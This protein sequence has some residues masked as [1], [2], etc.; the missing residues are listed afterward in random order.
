MKLFLYVYILCALP[1]FLLSQTNKAEIDTIHSTVII[2]QYRWLED[3]NAAETKSWIKDQKKA[4]QKALFKIR[5]KEKAFS[6]INKYSY[7]EVDLPIKEGKHFYKL[8]YY[9]L[10]TPPGLFIQ[11]SI[12]DEPFRIFSPDQISIK[13]EIIISDYEESNDGKYLALSYGRN[14]S[15]WK[16]IKVKKI[17]GGYLKDH[18]I[19]V[20]FS[21]IEWKDDGFFYLKYPHNEKF[22]KDLNPELLYHKLHTE[23]EEDQVIFRRKAKQTLEIGFDLTPSQDYLFIKEHNDLTGTRNIFIKDLSEFEN[24][25]RPLLM[26]F[27]ND[28]KILANRGDT[29]IAQTNHI[30]KNQSIVYF[31]IQ[32]PYTW[33]LLIPSYNDALLVYSKI[34]NNQIICKYQIATKTKLIFYDL[35]GN[36]LHALDFPEGYNVGG[37]NGNSSDTEAIYYYTSYFLPPIVKKINL[38]DFTTELI[39]K[40]GVT[41]D[42]EDFEIESTSYTSFDG[43]QVPMTIVYKK[44]IVKNGKNPTLLK[45]YGGFGSIHSPGFDEGLIYFME[46]GGV[47][48]YCHVRGEGLLG[49]DWESGGKKLNKQNSIND[50]ISAAE[51][52]IEENYTNPKQLAI[53]GSS[54]GGLLVGAAMTQ[55]PDLYKVAV[56]VVGVF[57]MIRFEN[58]TVGSFHKDEFGTTENEIEFQNLLSYSPYHN[59][60]PG[61]NYPAT[62]IMTSDNDERVPPFHSFKFAAKLQ[63][64]PGQENPVLLRIEEKAGHYGA[65]NV[66]NE[67]EEKTDMYAFIFHYLK[68][69]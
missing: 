26:K 16:E 67:L 69:E 9:Q 53:T 8:M 6:S 2:D 50:F 65:N 13:D 5:N 42:I 33:N 37:F 46:N 58:F 52:L 11:N 24:P 38:N 48:A 31:T 35:Y 1:T 61:V 30:N 29:I 63:N 55:R 44:G 22:S 60:E 45:T 47:F 64:N 12:N 21:Q 54:H 18:L 27:E 25:I 68:N 7:T 57:D 20:K 19:D 3:L 17:K 10:N 43:K 59:I 62:L 34:M 56:P 66:V 23:Q 40:T 14:G 36:I 39:Q 4:T 28:V 49:F 15:D 32:D 51:F 41:F